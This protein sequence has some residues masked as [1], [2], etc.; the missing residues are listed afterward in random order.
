[1]TVIDNLFATTQLS[2]TRAEAIRKTYMLLGLSV[3][4][5]LCGGDPP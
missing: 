1:M 3:A 5:A 2:S 4:G